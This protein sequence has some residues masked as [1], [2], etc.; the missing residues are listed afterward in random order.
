LFK[1][2]AMALFNSVAASGDDL[3]QAA[4]TCSQAAAVRAAG[5]LHV[6]LI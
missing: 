2:L 3:L 1:Q 6:G 5:D 4:M